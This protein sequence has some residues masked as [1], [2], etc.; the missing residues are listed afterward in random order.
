MAVS[1]QPLPL[2]Y[3]DFPAAAAAS[4]AN[5][6]KAN[7]DEVVI[8]EQP[9]GSELTGGMAF[10][11]YAQSRWRRRRYFHMHTADTSRSDFDLAGLMLRCGQ[12]G[13]ETVIVPL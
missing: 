7:K 4:T 9:S 12:G 10:C 11:A 1:R 5:G 3:P 8:A 13:P 6:A 2:P